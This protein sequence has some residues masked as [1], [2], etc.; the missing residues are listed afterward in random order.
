MKENKIT[1]AVNGRSD[2]TMVIRKNEM[3]KAVNGRSIVSSDL[4]F[5][6]FVISFSF[7]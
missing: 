6:A 1:K 3:T 4:P 2:D 5:T 7:L